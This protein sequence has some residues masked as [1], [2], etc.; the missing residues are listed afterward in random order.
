MG[1]KEGLAGPFRAVVDAG[2]ESQTESVGYA[3]YVAGMLI[4][5]GMRIA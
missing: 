5:A 1:Q 2:Y 3:A 4:A